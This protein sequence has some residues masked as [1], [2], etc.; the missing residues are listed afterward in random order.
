MANIA[1]IEVEQGAGNSCELSLLRIYSLMVCKAVHDNENL[2]ASGSISLGIFVF[3]NP[4]PQGGDSSVHQLGAP[5]Q[6]MMC[7]ISSCS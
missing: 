4:R 2:R 5:T 3:L 6:N 1:L 7:I